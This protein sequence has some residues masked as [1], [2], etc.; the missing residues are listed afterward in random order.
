MVIVANSIGIWASK[1]ATNDGREDPLQF[2]I[3]CY[4]IM[5][6]NLLE[7]TINMHTIY[8]IWGFGASLNINYKMNSA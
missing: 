7:Q 3:I 5:Q 8:A 6:D 1:N 2:C 4:D